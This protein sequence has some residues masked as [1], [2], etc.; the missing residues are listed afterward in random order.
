MLFQKKYDFTLWT[1]YFVLQVFDI[2]IFKQLVI[3]YIEVTT[4]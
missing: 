2:K 3:R 1:Y 4:L